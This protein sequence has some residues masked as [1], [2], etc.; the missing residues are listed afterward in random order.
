MNLAVQVKTFVELVGSLLSA[1]GSNGM[2]SRSPR[3]AQGPSLEM[4]R[5]MKEAGIIKALTD[6]LALMDLDHPKVCMHTRMQ[7]FGRMHAHKHAVQ[8]KVCSQFAGA[9][10]LDDLL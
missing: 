10:E 9:V 4:A 7:A 2:P 6:A 5:A 8:V 1:S 3:P